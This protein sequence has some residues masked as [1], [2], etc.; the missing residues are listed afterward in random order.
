MISIPNRLFL[1]SLIFVLFFG[2]GILRSTTSSVLA[3]VPKVTAGAVVDDNGVVNEDSLKAFV[4]WATDLSAKIT[5]ITDGYALQQAIYDST[6]DY[7]AGNIYLV[8]F[9]VGISPEV[10]GTIQFHPEYRDVEG[11][12]AA[13]VVDEEGN[14][15]VEEMLK[16][17]T[18]EPVRVEYCWNDP[19]DDSDNAAGATCKP[20]YAQRYTSTVA[21]YDL[22][23]VGGYHQDLN[24]LAVTPPNIPL[25]EV[26]AAEV[27]D[28]ETLRQFVEGAAK[29]SEAVFDS[30]GVFA[31]SHWKVEFR[32]DSKDGGLFKDGLV[33]LYSMNPEG[34]VIFHG[35]DAWREGRIVLHNPDARGDTLFVGR[36]IKAALED[37]GG[38][39]DYY[40]DNPEDPNDDQG[41]TLRTAYGVKINRQAS[42]INEEYV[43]AGAFFPSINTSINNEA[44]ELPGEFTLYGNYPNPFNPSTRI[45]FDLPESARVSLQ[46]IDLLGRSVMELPSESFEAGTRHTIQLDATNLVSGTYLYR[47]L[48]IGLENRYEKTGIM[49]LMK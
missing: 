17:G 30:L 5:N 22:I 46:V 27:V 9:I 34:L 33:Y 2:S 48:A 28:R 13:R 37:G 40:W 15:V 12:P 45:Q 24:D 7:W 43:L 1:A 8:Y 21:N 14:K 47:V 32:K 31:L 18:Q 42:N 41:G 20:S 11:L 23:V 6:G 38:F 26:T 29:W 36:I 4:A 10:D 35:L 19:E 16:A 25:P 44:T 3:Q 49:T 39:V